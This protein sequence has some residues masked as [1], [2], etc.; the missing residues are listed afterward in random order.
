MAYPTKKKTKCLASSVQKLW[1]APKISNVGHVTLD[2]GP[3]V[4]MARAT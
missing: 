2:T 3:K 1:R 4:G